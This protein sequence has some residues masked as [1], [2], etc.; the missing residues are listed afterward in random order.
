[1]KQYFQLPLVLC[2]CLVGLLAGC[3]QYPKDPEDTLT[4]VTGGTLVVGYSEN[5]P[6]V[7]DGA[8]GP[9]GLEADLV[10]GYAKTINAQI[11][12]KKD[13][14]QDLLHA[15]EENQLHV[16]IAG[17][18]D[19]TPWKKNISFTRPYAEL[20]KKKHVFCVIK[21][22][23]ALVTSLEKYLHSQKSVIEKRLQP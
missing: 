12:W 2:I 9:S 23:N 1:M 7:V 10:R 18:T 20:E 4:K 3:T 17:I 22:E 14:E 19:D 11:E 6:W 8:N 15:L 16:V 5:A 21:G 13:T